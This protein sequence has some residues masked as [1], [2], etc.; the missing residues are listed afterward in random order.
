VTRKQ[1]ILF[2]G[3]ETKDD[4]FPIFIHLLYQHMH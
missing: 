3:T 2:L 4:L 1:D